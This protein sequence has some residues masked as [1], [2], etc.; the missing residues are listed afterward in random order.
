TVSGGALNYAGKF[1]A[2]LSPDALGAKPVYLHVDSAHIHASSDALVVPDAQFLF[3]A[4]FKRSGADLILSKDGQEL[5]FRDYFKGEHPVALASPD[6]A[7][8]TGNIVSA[9]T[10]AHVQ[11]SQAGGGA[12]AAGVVIGH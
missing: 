2:A 7:H 5:T 12:S 8:L 11:V 6:G 10:G 9:L 4:N 1:D 3:H